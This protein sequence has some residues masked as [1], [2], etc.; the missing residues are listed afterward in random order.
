MST[1]D[2]ESLFYELLHGMGLMNFADQG[3]WIR[4]KALARHLEQPSE[5]QA[6]HWVRACKHMALWQDVIGVV[7]GCGSDYDVVRIKPQ[8][9]SDGRELVGC[10]VPKD[11]RP[12]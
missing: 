11:L 12:R 4:D 8:R 9:V 7:P 3:S 2:P 5:V 1:R 10:R 6:W